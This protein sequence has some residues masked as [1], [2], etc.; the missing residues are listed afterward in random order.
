MFIFIVAT[1]DSD[2]G[3]VIDRWLLNTDHLVGINSGRLYLSHHVLGA[4]S[5]AIEPD[6]FYIPLWN[7][8]TVETKIV[9]SLDLPR[10]RTLNRTKVKEEG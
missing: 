6:S 2:H 10:A 8:H 4:S 1:K 7:Y 3:E 9:P 5:T